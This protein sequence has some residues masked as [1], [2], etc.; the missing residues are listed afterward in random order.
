MAKIFSADEVTNFIQEC[1]TE[2]DLLNSVL[3][4]MCSGTEK[5]V[6]VADGIVIDNNDAENHDPYD[7]A[8]DNIDTSVEQ[9]TD[10]INK[11]ESVLSEMNVKD[12]SVI[13]NNEVTTEYNSIYTDDGIFANTNTFNDEDIVFEPN[14]NQR[15]R[16][17]DENSWKQNISK[18]KR[19][20]GEKYI[21]KSLNRESGLWEEI[22]KPPRKR[23]PICRR[24][25]C[26]KCKKRC[27][28]EFNDEDCEVI[29]SSYWSSGGGKIQKTFIQSLVDKEETR[30]T[31]VSSESRRSSTYVYRLKK[32]GR[33]LV[34]CKNMF[35]DTLG[36]S[37][38]KV[39][40]A[41]TE[42]MVGVCEN[43]VKKRNPRPSRGF[44]WTSEDHSLLEKKFEDIPKAPGHYCRKDSK[45]VYLSTLIPTMTKLY[46]IYKARCIAFGRLPFSIYK[47]T[48]YFKD[49]N[50]SL[51]RRKKDRCNTCVG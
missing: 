40:S 21:G 30:I 42:T 51:F 17:R 7:I 16:K 36:I 14:T 38:K 13:Q 15:K 28:D 29:F 45:K 48:E 4:K 22:E 35:L 31:V 39:R 19:A 46:E 11:N 44:H 37:E 23:G 18:M 2:D 33:S 5:S 50:Y 20:R 47:F 10:G 49:Q 43:N 24:E 3:A 9:F 25:F 12:L 6:E 41:L 26:K 32:D 8:G 34:V 1:E 27:C